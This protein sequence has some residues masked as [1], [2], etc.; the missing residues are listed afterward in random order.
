[1]NGFCNTT[2]YSPTTQIRIS[3]ALIFTFLNSVGLI[4]NFFMLFIFIKHRTQFLHSF[5]IFMH[6]LIICDIGALMNKF[7][8]VIPLTLMN[9]LPYSEFT[10]NFLSSFGTLFFHTLLFL[11]F[12]IAINRFAVFF[13]PNYHKILF[14]R[15]YVYV[16]AFTP[17]I[18][19]FC[20]TLATTFVGCKKTFD[21][22]RFINYFACPAAKYISPNIACFMKI[23]SFYVRLMPYFMLVLYIMLFAY[24]RCKKI[25][26]GPHHSSAV[27]E[28]RILYQAVIICLTISATTM[29]FW[30]VPLL[31]TDLWASLIVQS[32]SILNYSIN[33]FI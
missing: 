16:T 18:V 17:W 20:V 11:S 12:L 9:N 6:H 8:V 1:M 30:V 5:Y 26:T 29:C 24:V 14:D 7:L 21:H 27:K 19:G 3:Y 2:S 15:P 31:I 25:K 13:A 33:P 10:E 4:A 32:C 23:L 22:C 28:M